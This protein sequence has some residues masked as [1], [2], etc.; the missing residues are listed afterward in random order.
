MSDVFDVCVECI[1]AAG[2]HMEQL[3]SNDQVSSSMAQ[4]PKIVDRRRLHEATEGPLVEV[5]RGSKDD[6]RR[7]RT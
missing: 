3:W 4:G 7:K 5:H 2:T 1:G 6:D